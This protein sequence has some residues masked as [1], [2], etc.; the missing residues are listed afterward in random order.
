MNRTVPLRLYSI[1]AAFA[2]LALASAPARAW[3]VVGGGGLPVFAAG[4]APAASAPA[5]GGAA[6]P[7]GVAPAQ[8]SG[9]NP[10]YDFR[11]GQKFLVGVDTKT[12]FAATD[13]LFG[14]APGFDASRTSMKFGYDMGRFKP[15]VMSSFTDIRP[16]FGAVSFSGIGAPP[17]VA[18]PFAP[19]AKVSTVGA[20]FDYAVTDKL[21]FGVSV[22]ASQATT[23]WGR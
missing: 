4:V 19:S 18:T 20:G 2:S 9:F 22:S 23:G 1:A 12:G 10:G 13:G 14:F 17:G 15:F 7:L 5:P 21:S 11:I 8:F 16:S 6:G 3:E